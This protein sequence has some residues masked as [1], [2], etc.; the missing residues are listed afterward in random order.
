LVTQDT[1]QNAGKLAVK[2]EASPMLNHQTL[3]AWA[4]HQLCKY[5]VV[6]EW[7]KQGI[8]KFQITKHS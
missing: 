1:D 2:V 8:T 7:S 3:G 5:D 4:H 6:L